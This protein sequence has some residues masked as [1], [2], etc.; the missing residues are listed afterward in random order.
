MFGPPEK[1]Y[2]TQVSETPCLYVRH[3]SGPG[4]VAWFPWQ[5]AAHYERQGHAGHKALVVAA[6]DELLGL[7]RRVRI[8]A[9][10]LVEINHRG[11][12][13][14]GFEW[15][16]LVNHSGSLDNVLHDPIPI[17][18]VEIQ[19]T[20]RSSVR[21]VRLLREG[22]EIPFMQNADGDVICVVPELNSYEVV[23]LQQ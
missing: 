6:L 20:P 3:A 13:S 5:I 17:R 8:E 2:Y 15:I 22:R 1:C 18:D 11:G 12:R 10:P 9:S 7:P 23:L 16:S 21:T 14:G 19:V 4:A